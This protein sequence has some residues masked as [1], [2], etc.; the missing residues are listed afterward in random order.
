M[1]GLYN[2]DTVSHM[3]SKS[4]CCWFSLLLCL[5]CMLLLHVFTGSRQRLTLRWKMHLLKLLNLLWGWLLSQSFMKMCCQSYVMY[6]SS[7]GCM[8]GIIHTRIPFFFTYHLAWIVCVSI[9]SL[10]CT[11]SSFGFFNFDLETRFFSEMCNGCCYRK[12]KIGIVMFDKFYMIADMEKY[13][14]RFRRIQ[15]AMADLLIAL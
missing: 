8:V 10:Q 3:V 9:M 5:R 7:H 11:I 12:A 15:R 6:H 14:M 2:L 4:Q 1:F 13:W